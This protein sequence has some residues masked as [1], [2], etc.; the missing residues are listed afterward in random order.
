MEEHI[1]MRNVFFGNTAVMGGLLYVA[2]LGSG[3]YSVVDI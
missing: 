3:A 2:V 1:M